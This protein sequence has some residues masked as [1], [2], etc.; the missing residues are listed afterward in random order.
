MA[1]IARTTL[2]RQRAT[3]CVLAPLH[4]VHWPDYGCLVHPGSIKNVNL[5]EMEMTDAMEVLELVCES[6]QSTVS[7]NDAVAYGRQFAT[8]AIR[9]PPGGMP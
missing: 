5:M 3:E 8:D 9:V 2:T 7:A 6:Y 4:S 1:F